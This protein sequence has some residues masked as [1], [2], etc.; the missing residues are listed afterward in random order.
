LIVRFFFLG[1]QHVQTGPDVF[2]NSGVEETKEAVMGDETQQFKRRFSIERLSSSESSDSD[3][4]AAMM[5]NV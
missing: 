2:G 4:S 5:G 3:L 1:H